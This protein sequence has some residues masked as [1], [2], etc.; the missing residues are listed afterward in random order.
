MFD[1]VNARFDAGSNA[2]ISAPPVSGAASKSMNPFTVPPSTPVA[3]N[4]DGTKSSFTIVPVPA[5]VPSTVP[6]VVFTIPE[7]VRITVSP[8]SITVS[9]FTVTVTVCDSAPPA[10]KFSVPAAIAT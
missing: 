8:A 6:P 5:A 10:A 4:L 3:G 7:S 9:P 1:D 2:G